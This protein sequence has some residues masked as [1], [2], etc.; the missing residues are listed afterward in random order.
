MDEAVSPELERRLKCNCQVCATWKRIGVVIGIAHESVRFH[1]PARDAL[2]TAF[3]ELLDLSGSHH[4]G[5]SAPVAAGGVPGPNL[6]PFPVPIPTG[7]GPGARAAPKSKEDETPKSLPEKGEKRK[8]SRSRRR[9]KSAAKE[10]EESKEG[11]EQSSVRSSKNRESSQAPSSRRSPPLKEVKEELEEEPQRSASSPEEEREATS[12]RPS[13][14]SPLPSARVKSPPGSARSSGKEKK[15]RDREADLPPGVWKLTPREPDHPPP[16]RP[17][18]P[19]D[20]PSWY[21]KS[22]SKHQRSKG[23]KARVRLEDIHAFG[24]DPERKKWRE[25]W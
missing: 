25:S 24:P 3:N 10:E 11:Q 20:P 23:I 21:R 19:S 12:A 13:K 17:P 8:R 9:K 6:P 22:P 15:H 1:W 5:P 16:H 4:L 14:K 2:R 18:E 7:G